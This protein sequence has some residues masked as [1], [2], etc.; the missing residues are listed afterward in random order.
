V[1]KSNPSQG[2][3]LSPAAL[4]AF[5]FVLTVIAVAQQYLVDANQGVHTAIL[6][7]VTVIGALG[8]TSA[9]AA[10]LGKLIPHGVAMVMVTVANVLQA[11]LGLSDVG[12]SAHA[13]IGGALVLLASLAINPTS[14]IK[15]VPPSKR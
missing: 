1:N 15:P 2:L 12:Q 4:G 10:K 11:L 8:A 5:G 7:T 3:V 6:L 14:P 9:D 13:L